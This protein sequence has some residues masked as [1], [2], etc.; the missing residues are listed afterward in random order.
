MRTIL[1]FPLH[2]E[3]PGFLTLTLSLSLFS[4]YHI[5]LFPISLSK[6]ASLHFLYLSP[7]SSLLSLSLSLFFSVP[8]LILYLHP[9]YFYYLFVSFK[10]FSLSLA[11][12]S[13]LSFSSHP[14]L[15]PSLLPICL[16]LSLLSSLFSLFLSP[17]SLL[18]LS[19][20]NIFSFSFSLL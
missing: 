8:T 2:E 13:A 3:F 16:P 5:S 11:H 4:F 1:S 20:P 18:F 19:K 6:P 17:H 12:L 10:Y 9:F 14:F 7:L 15:S